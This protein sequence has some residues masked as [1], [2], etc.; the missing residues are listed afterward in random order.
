MNRREITEE[1]FREEYPVRIMCGRFRV[2]MNVN[3]KITRDLR[4]LNVGI[5]EINI[6]IY[7][8]HRK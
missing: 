1:E 8:E 2:G 3:Y 5:F 4:S 6:G 7:S